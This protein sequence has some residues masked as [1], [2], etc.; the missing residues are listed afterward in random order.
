M[1]TS[2]R[3]VGILLLAALGLAALLRL[4]AGPALAQDAS[5]AA[6]A[7]TANGWSFTDVIRV[8]QDG[9]TQVGSGRA[10]PG[11][12]VVVSGQRN[13]Q[14][15]LFRVEGGAVVAVA[16]EGL[17]LPGG[18][19][20]LTNIGASS[21]QYAV[22]P[23]GDVVFAASATGGS[24]KLQFRYVFRWSDGV[25]TLAQPATET[26]PVSQSQA[27]EHDLLQV[28]TDGRWLAT[29]TTGVFPNTTTDYGLTDGTTR[30]PLFSFTRSSAGCVGDRVLRA[31]AN[32]GDAIATYR[33][34]Q[35]RSAAGSACTDPTTRAWSVDLA[36][37][38][39]GTVVTGVSTESGNSYTGV[40]LSDNS[41]FLVNNQ[42]QVAAVRE[43]HNAPTTFRVREQLVVF[44]GTG[45]TLVQDSDGPVDSM[46]L[47]DFDQQGHVLYSASLDSDPAATV[48]LAG[49]DLENDRVV[50]TGDALFG[51]TV[52]G[53][54]W[55]ARPAAVGEG[56]ERAFAF[57]Y[58][59]SDGARGVALARRE[60]PRWINPAGGNW[61]AAAN[62]T[63]AE[64]P[65]PD[66]SVRFDLPA[67]YA[68]TL[69]VEQAGGVQVRN[70]DVVLANGVLTTAATGFALDIS[71]ES[72]GVTP[73]L[74]LRNVEVF[75]A[76]G[77]GLNGPGE[78]R[79]EGGRLSGSAGGEQ[80]TTV[81]GFTAPATATV[82]AGGSWLWRE[83]ALGLAHPALLR[84]EDG[85]LAGFGSKRLF[86]GGSVLGLPLRNQSARAVVTNATDNGGP[87]DLGTLLG[88]V[89]ELIVGEALAGRL[90]VSDG[91]RA[92]AVTTTVG[93]RDHGAVTDGILTVQGT[94]AAH[95]ASFESGQG[96]QGGLFVATGDRTDA[97]VTVSGGGVMTLTRLSLADGA[98]SN[99]VMFVDGL[100]AAD[101]G[102]RRSTV[103]A[104]VPPAQGQA[105]A[106]SAG[107][108]DCVIG[109]AGQGTLNVSF[110]GL[111]RCRQ[112][113]VGM[114]P[115]S[116]GALNIDGI[117]RS[118]NARVAA[119][120][121]LAEDGAVCIGRVGLCGATA[122]AVRGEVIVGLDGILEGR[123]IGVGN[124][125]RLRGSGLAIARE[126][127]V[128][129][130]GGS[131]APGVV[132][133]GGTQAASVAA[134]EVGTLTIQGN[135]TVSTTG[136]IT[137]HV[138]GPTPDRQ[139]RLEVSG[140]LTLDGDLAIHFGDGYAPKRGDRLALIQAASISGTPRSVIISGLEPG[141]EADLDVSGGSVTLVARNDGQATAGSHSLYLPA[142]QRISW[143]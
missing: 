68:V 77:I 93:T 136:V 95:P 5:L 72:A 120:G 22:L 86:V 133:L 31:A 69:G 2:F 14:T 18:L 56:D 10:G 89:N 54:A 137:L 70:G 123:I 131:V 27:F 71:G 87:L 75:A 97:E 20:T 111:V 61:A 41:L 11:G 143:R 64:V 67:A 58:G 109:N 35:T 40:E 55:V 119:D 44:S 106:A 65:G 74:T 79:I 126:G 28:T 104:P 112:I 114:G 24:L 16:T 39:A 139:D 45:E 107:T 118:I 82:A 48:L 15:G 113:A 80:P 91:G 88:P 1:R 96:D 99:A 92:L 37:G 105:G 50:G 134:G 34:V 122:G 141:F 63:P 52:T 53:L 125:G 60:P 46:F 4:P 101:G 135:L 108:G 3:A 121:P 102:E 100:E 110:G 73:R 94:N 66:S 26:D 21:F 57:T 129:F 51:H 25:I 117:L 115:G 130:D 90:E 85:A 47:A 81:L 84:V 9:F 8:G 32:A 49:P 78:L 142:V 116:R 33:E 62:W 103:T 7:V 12:M 76:A 29:L 124:G 13:G 23:N 38:A 19:G 6:A 138:L 128:V 98:Q 59:L 140:A 30:Q 132:Q 42:N 17:A 83:L 43:V 127:V 36:G